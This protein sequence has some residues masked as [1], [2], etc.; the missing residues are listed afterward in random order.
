MLV[1]MS[2]GLAKS[3]RDELA[4]AIENFG[5]AVHIH[6]AIDRA[7]TIRKDIVTLISPLTIIRYIEGTVEDITSLL[8][9]SSRLTEGDIEKLVESWDAIL[10]GLF[11]IR[12]IVEKDQHPNKLWDRV[13]ASKNMIEIRRH[14]SSLLA[15]V[16]F[17]EEKAHDLYDGR[18]NAQTQYKAAI[19]RIRGNLEKDAR[20]HMSTIGSSHKLPVHEEDTDLSKEFEA[21]SLNKFDIE[22]LSSEINPKKTIIVFDEAGCIPSY[23]LLGLSRLGRDIQ[24]L[25]LVGDKCQLPPYDASQGR[26]PRSQRYGSSQRFGRKSREVNSVKSLLDVSALSID[27]SK[28][29]LG[30][31][32]R[33]PKDIA[34][35]LNTRV[36]K[37]HY[38]TCPSSDIP[39]KGLRVE[40]VQRDPRPRKKYVN[41]YEVRRGLELVEELDCDDRIASILVITPVSV[42]IAFD[43]CSIYCCANT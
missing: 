3:M 5:E 18:N 7:E 22:D 12:T 11:E 24:A 28:V 42:G 25:I 33:V 19:D 20:V 26:R 4:T 31:Q 16:T 1:E 15:L 6:R 10:N 36:Y 30:T 23:E 13:N 34:D 27:D 35:M 29:V 39:R 41:A 37:G 17:D 32:Y 43:K 2:K 38:K 21:L 9:G 14:L 8:Q 40:H